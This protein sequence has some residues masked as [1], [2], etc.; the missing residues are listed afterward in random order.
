[1]GGA[2]NKRN[3]PSM[4]NLGFHPTL[5]WD[6]RM[7]SLEACANAAW[8]GQLGGDPVV[9]AK[10]LNEVPVYRA[11]FNRAFETKEGATAENVPRALAAFLRTLGSGNSPWD[12]FT[13]GD[14]KALSK[15]AQQG[16]TVF[17]KS[18]CVTCHVAPLFSDFDFHAL[19]VNDDAGRKDATKLDG[20]LGKF[21]TPSLRGVALSAPYLHDG[22]AKTLEDAIAFMARGGAVKAGSDPKLKAVKLSAKEVAAVKAFLESLTGDVTVTAAPK[23]P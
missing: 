3:A 8:K 13:A 2:V 5:Y 19:G 11:M 20:D 22:S 15:E 9:V 12:R 17:Q 23:L 16:W 6:G 4:L 1:V 7:P 10:K 21:K 14:K 18:G